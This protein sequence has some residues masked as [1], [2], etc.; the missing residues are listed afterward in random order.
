M[1]GEKGIGRSMDPGA[2]EMLA[3]GKKKCP[4]CGKY[5]DRGCRIC[6]ECS[7]DL[8][9]RVKE[10]TLIKYSMIF[11]VLAVVYFIIAATMEPGIT[12]IEDVK[13]GDKYSLMRFKGTVVETPKYYPVKYEEFGTMK[14][15]INDTTA[16]MTVYFDSSTTK[17]LIESGNVPAFGDEVDVMGSVSYRKM[18]ATMVDDYTISK[19]GFGFYLTDVVKSQEPRRSVSV[20]TEDNI[21]IAKNEYKKMKFSSVNEL[22]ITRDKYKKVM[23]SGTVVSEITNFSS[24]YQFTIGD[25][26]SGDKILVYIPKD[27]IEL[28]GIELYSEDDP[29]QNLTPGSE[30][31]ILGALE[32]YKSDYDTKDTTYSKWELIPTS[33]GRKKKISGR[34]CFEIGKKGP[35]FSVDMLLSNPDVY[36]DEQVKL[37]GVTLDKEDYDLCLKGSS[38]DEPIILYIPN[39]F[40]NDHPDLLYDY[41]D[42]D[43]VDIKGQFIYYEEGNKWEIK[44]SKDYHY[45][46][47]VE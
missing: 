26:V 7:G 21:E 35:G 23:A 13:E 41:E 29:V 22:N 18:H 17:Y 5:I 31:T 12:D 14:L 39:Y 8:S 43:T 10:T 33:L 24:A 6:P 36:K 2:E 15:V 42:G 1:K 11:I 25:L 20:S 46:R 3:A 40:K 45:I 19:N 44:L 16:E 38:S 28:S 27:V 34:Y 4:A 47:E 32:Y 30:I 9:Y 37:E